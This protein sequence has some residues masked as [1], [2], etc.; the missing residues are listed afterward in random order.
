ME[1]YNFL[2]ENFNGL[3]DIDELKNILY[4]KNIAISYENSEQV[5]NRFNETGQRTRRIIF[6]ASNKSK[7]DPSDE[8]ELCLEANGMILNA[9]N[10]DPLVIPPRTHKQIINRNFVKKALADGLY[11][12]YFTQDGTIVTLYWYPESKRWCMSSQNGIDITNVAFNNMTYG[13][14]FS[15]VLMTYGLNPQSFFAGLDK[16]ICYTLGFKHNDIH[17]FQEG[18][19]KPLNLIWF[20]QMVS[21][22]NYLKGDMQAITESPWPQIH[23]HRMVEPNKGKVKHSLSEL[24]SY[25]TNSLDIFRMEKS[26]NYGYLL[27]AKPGTEEQFKNH[28]GHTS[29]LLESKLLRY[30]R[31]LWYNNKNP[32]FENYDISNRTNLVL[33]DVFLKEGSQLLMELFPQYIRK[34]NDLVITE[35]TLVNAIYNNLLEPIESEISLNAEYT[36]N[37]IIKILSGQVKN[38]VNIDT[39]ANP[40]Q[41]IKDVI[42]TVDNFDYYYKFKNLF[43]II[44]LEDAF[45]KM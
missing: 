30:I 7:N 15:E 9:P 34:V 1:L 19:D 23:G 13:D 17:P 24:F 39:V 35:I 28:M 40:K 41:K 38:H 36:I 21:I 8:S 4:K 42:H 29:I 16:T 45:E 27:V 43:D 6:N 37:D 26:L 44:N 32:L 3:D 2:K 25:L 11:D 20:V 5:I 18:L 14:M 12:L 31:L 22:P 10:W 33:L